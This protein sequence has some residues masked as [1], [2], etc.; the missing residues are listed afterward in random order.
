LGLLAYGSDP[1]MNI[2]MQLNFVE[3]PLFLKSKDG[4]RSR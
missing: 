3:P 1:R 4:A 2:E